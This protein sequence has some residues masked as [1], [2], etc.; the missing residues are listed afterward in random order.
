[1]VP[2]LPNAQQALFS[3]EDMLATAPNNCK[4]GSASVNE[5]Q[6]L[7]GL[8]PSTQCFSLAT[9]SQLHSH[10]SPGSRQESEQSLRLT[11]PRP[12]CLDSGQ[13]L[14]VLP[15]VL[16]NNQVKTLI[17][18]TETQDRVNKS[19]NITKHATCLQGTL[20]SPE[21]NDHETAR[22]KVRLHSLKPDCS[23]QQAPLPKRLGNRNYSG[24]KGHW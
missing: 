15:H 8:S 10:Q 24:S 17:E 23:S 16:D 11:I 19:Q 2:G 18:T 4:G 20:L 7:A 22:C 1:M 6:T 12:A 5:R 21:Q 3:R 14:A 9:R 13:I